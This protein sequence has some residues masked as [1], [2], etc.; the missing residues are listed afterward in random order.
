M[1]SIT[2]DRELAETHRLDV[3]R[4]GRT[5]VA[6]SIVDTLIDLAKG[7]PAPSSR[8]EPGRVVLLLSARGVSVAGVELSPHMAEQLRRSLA[9]SGPVTIGD[10]TTMRRV[11]SPLVYLVANTIMNDDDKED[12]PAS[13]PTRQPI[14]TWAVASRWK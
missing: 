7:G 3:R 5:G 8:S 13:S 9:L 14:S 6:R 11:A 10:M 12:Q 4:G 1:G 2:G